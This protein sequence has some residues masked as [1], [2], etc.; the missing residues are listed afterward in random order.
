MSDTAPTPAPPTPL[1]RRKTDRTR[2]PIQELR[3]WLRKHLKEPRS[4]LWRAG[5]LVL[6]SLCCA[7]LL[8][9]RQPATPLLQAGEIA[10]RSVWAQRNYRIPDRERSAAK[11]AQAERLARPVYDFDPGVAA[12]AIG[13]LSAGFRNARAAAPKRGAAERDAHDR[14][15]RFARDVGLA[16]SDVPAVLART[17]FDPAIERATILLL[18][19]I[20]DRKIVARADLVTTDLEAGITVRDVGGGEERLLKGGSAVLDIDGAEALLAERVAFALKDESAARRRLA[21]ALATAVLRPNLTF[22]AAETEIRRRRAREG[23][24]EFV[25]VIQ[26]GRAV[27]Q[28]GDEISEAQA[29]LLAAMRM[30][31]VAAGRTRPFANLG[32]FLLSASILGGV[33]AF[34][35]RYMRRIPQETADL[36]VLAS[37]VL[38]GLLLARGAQELAEVLSD[39]GTLLSPSLL[40]YAIPA[41]ST[42][43]VAAVLFGAD[44]AALVATATAL[45]AGLALEGDLR[46]TIYIFLGSITAAG[47]LSLPQKR[48]DLIK[49]GLAAAVA[50]VALVIAFTLSAADPVPATFADV[51]SVA[52]LSGVGAGIIAV[53]VLPIYEA[54]GYLTN[55]KLLELAS[56]GSP[57]L[58]ELSVQAPGTYHHSV[59]VGSLAEAAAEAVGANPL[60]ARVACYYHDIGKMKKPHYFIENQAGRENLHDRLTPSMSALV[61]ESHVKDGIEMGLAHGLPRAIVDM[62]PQHHGTRLISFF[63]NKAKANAEA[64]PDGAQVEESDFRYPGPKP[65]SPEAGIIMLAD[66]VEAST[67]TI[68]DPTPAKIQAMI[69]KV[70]SIVQGDGQLDECDLSLKDLGR[71]AAAFEKV[72]MAIHHKRVAYPSTAE[73]AGVIPMRA[74][75]LKREGK[76]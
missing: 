29:S 70:F 34:G 49:A 11:R 51:A 76:E 72:V 73:I 8:D 74:A 62:I 17:A 68:T 54:F 43:I 15:E 40:R 56:L 48:T 16:G 9:R 55:F 3:L 52:L 36:A 31:E 1:R 50:Q 69:R 42:A 46:E 38:F 7:L 12:V 35:R 58:K 32:L 21:L 13:R 47:M 20:S 64:D 24:E 37:L 45:L 61:V 41:A 66:G 10:S 71:I 4:P 60:F 75:A 18:E 44:G 67:R 23:V 14:A 2:P 65:Q 19:S 27:V 39:R 22:N 6:A 28:A 63:Y 26:K 57:L 30:E 5:L 25:S 59:V 53:G 33:W